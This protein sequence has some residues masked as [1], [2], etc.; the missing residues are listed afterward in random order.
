LSRV[1]EIGI[2]RIK[3]EKTER[4]EQL[5]REIADYRLPREN[6]PEG[7]HSFRLYRAIEDPHRFAL[8]LTWDS[9]EDHT[10]SA[11]SAWGKQTA[12]VLQ[13]CLASE[14]DVQHYQLVEGTA[15]GTPDLSKVLQISILPVKPEKV[16]TFEQI[17]REIV[18]FRSRPENQASE[19][20]G[21]HSS[22]LYRALEDPTRYLRHGT[23][24][25]AEDHLRSGD[26]ERGKR[27]SGILRECLASPAVRH[28]Y[29]VV[30]GASA[31]D[32]DL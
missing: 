11:E 24:N 28:H 26:T 27:L 23:W 6:Q 31:G 2:L 18:E 19:D 5:G 30:E 29:T 1:L 9:V 3:P 15:A 25:A 7:W 21:W 8:H 17:G 32:G 22:R 20:N 4:M 13:E 10:R 16:E 12:A 14:A